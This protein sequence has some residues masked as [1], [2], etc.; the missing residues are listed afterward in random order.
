MNKFLP[1][2]IV[3]VFA[4]SMTAAP[5]NITS[6]DGLKH[7]QR[8]PGYVAGSEDQSVNLGSTWGQEWD[9]EAFYFDFLTSEL[10][11]VG[12]F[13]AFGSNGGVRL[14]DVFITT[15]SDNY[16]VTFNHDIRGFADSNYTIVRLDDDITFI[17]VD[18]TYTHHNAAN[19]VRITG[20]DDGDVVA[21][22]AFHYEKIN[23][24]FRGFI[25]DED[26]N[27]HYLMSGI[28]LSEVGLSGQSFSLRQTMSCGNDVLYAHVP[29]PAILS[30]I[31]LGLISLAFFR[32]KK[33]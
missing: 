20:W 31:G 11:M 10:Q 23:G 4:A 8:G 18:P 13:N 14:G 27:D 9:L 25:G 6:N 2:M 1:V 29:E 24:D 26:N 5:I 21:S 15:G 17:D 3:A 33:K 19:P 32:N 16:A 7:S 22:G 30:F 12:G 28:D